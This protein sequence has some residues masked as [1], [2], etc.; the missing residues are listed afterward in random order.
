MQREAV[1]AG[2]TLVL[3]SLV[4]ATQ[5]H[6]LIGSTG[7]IGSSHQWNSSGVVVPL[8]R[9]VVCEQDDFLGFP[10]P[11]I[12]T[13]GI[14]GLCS[15]S[16]G[17]SGNPCTPTGGLSNGN[18]P[19]T[20]GACNS[21]LLLPTGRWFALQMT[22]SSGSPVPFYGS[23]GGHEC[24]VATT[25]FVYSEDYA[26]TTDNGHVWGVPVVAADEIAPGIPNPL[27]LG[28]YTIEATSDPG[29]YCDPLFPHFDQV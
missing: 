19:S 23:I 14:G 20:V 27:A 11:A 3:L 13:P 24:G 17:Y 5:A 9:V 28:S 26:L 29:V 18:A 1:L 22:D 25:T 8:L 21:G 6:H 4:T 10:A 16:P 12:A 15:M 2:S 7:P